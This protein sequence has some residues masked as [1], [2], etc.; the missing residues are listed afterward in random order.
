MILN[1][2]HFK[3]PKHHLFIILCLLL[4]CLYSGCS[5]QEVKLY[6][7]TEAE[8][9][10]IRF[11]K[12][13]F[14]RDVITR[15]VDD[16]LWIY[17]PYEEDI[18]KFQ[19][20]KFP[21]IPKFTV[22]FIDGNLK[23]A[24]LRFEYQI[25]ALSKT[26][27]NKGYSY[28]F[29]EETNKDFGLLLYGIRDKYFNAEH[30]PKF[31]IIVLADLINGVEFQYTIY[32]TDLK[33]YLDQAITPSEYY[34]RMLQD[35]R[36]NVLIIGDKIGRHLSYEKLEFSQFLVEQIMQRIRF[37]FTK[38]DFKLETTTEEEIFKIISYCA[39]TYEFREFSKVVLEN[40][41]SQDIITINQPALAEF[42]EF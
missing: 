10:F 27:K 18:L 37:K 14:N 24:A 8:E 41:E 42:K 22:V 15:H 34:N 25:V 39:D 5:R 1:L 19:V 9:G 21:Q 20:N 6:P 40:L 29:T 7:K 2:P 31:Y 38:A 26:E 23:D 12:E 35:L 13:E 32:G 3:F 17:L 30:Q 28:N 4:T 33:K 16:T 11:C 36:G